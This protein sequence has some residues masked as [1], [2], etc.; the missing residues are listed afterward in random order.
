LADCSNFCTGFP[1]ESFLILFSLT[2]R[3]GSYDS[4]ADDGRLVLQVLSLSDR[5]MLPGLKRQCEA[6]LRSRLDEVFHSF[7]QHSV[8]CM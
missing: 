2:Q 6:G 8:V 4:E 3:S 5:Y 7:H 1:N